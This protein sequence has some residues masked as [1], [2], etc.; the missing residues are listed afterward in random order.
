M[1]C[2]NSAFLCAVPFVC[3]SLY[4]QITGYFM[5]VSCRNLCATISSNVFMSLNDVIILNITFFSGDTGLFRRCKNAIKTKTK[6]KYLSTAPKKI[7]SNSIACSKFIRVACEQQQKQHT[8]RTTHKKS[9]PSVFRA[10]Y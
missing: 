6:T 7:V 1:C 10:F 3:Y 9:R 4:S 5:V 2:Y 8:Y